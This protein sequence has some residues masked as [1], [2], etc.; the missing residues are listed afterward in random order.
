MLVPTTSISNMTPLSLSFPDFK[1]A[2]QSGKRLSPRLLS[3]YL[4]IPLHI[5]YLASLCISTFVALALFFCLSPSHPLLLSTP[6]D[7]YPLANESWVAFHRAASQVSCAMPGAL[8]CQ[9]LRKACMADNLGREERRVPAPCQAK[10][11]V[12]TCL[13]PTKGIS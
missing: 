4:V 9:G 7:L 5:S 1:P 8:K 11:A 10:E 3:L 6:R 13:T 2:R 12:P